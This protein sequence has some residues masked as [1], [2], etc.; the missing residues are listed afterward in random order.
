[1]DLD[2]LKGAAVEHINELG[3]VAFHGVTRMTDEGRIL[4]W[5]TRQHP[6]FKEFL[7]G[8]AKLGIK[9]IV[10]HSR[11][12]SNELLDDLKA[13]LEDSS[14]S[15]AERRDCEKRLKALR[16]YA[17][18]TSNVELSFDFNDTIHL[19]ETHSDF[20]KEVLAVM[21]ELDMSLEPDEDSNPFDDD[22]DNTPPRGGFFSRN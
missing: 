4:M 6:D 2:R 12:L 11:E 9:L 8:A 22:D 18:F 14:L 21:S 7:A 17:G 10:V 5:D 13:E 15:M 1:M 3:M 20:M 19:F 16:P